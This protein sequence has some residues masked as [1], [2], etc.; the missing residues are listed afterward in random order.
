M[1]AGWRDCLNHHGRRT[2][3]TLYDVHNEGAA[4]DVR[5]P[6]GVMPLICHISARR[7][8]VIGNR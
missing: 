2:L 8:A 7:Y 3:S 5:R 1:V 4:A 6:D